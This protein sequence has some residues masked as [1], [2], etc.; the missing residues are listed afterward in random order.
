MTT[1][2]IEVIRNTI[3]I[4]DSIAYKRYSEDKA[5]DY[6]E[7]TSGKW[8]DEQKLIAPIIFPKF[9]EQILGFKLGETIGTEEPTLESRDTPDY[10][11]TDTRTHSFLFDCKGMDTF[12]LSKHYPQI[13]RY[14]E[15]QN[16]K[17]GVLVNM[18]DLTVYTN[19]SSEEVESFKFSFMELYKEFKSNFNTIL[20]N[21]NTK[22]F[23]RFVESFQYTPLTTEQKL[24][25]VIDAK[26]WVGTEILN[27]N[28]LTKR[29]HYIVE[30]IYED[31]ALKRYCQGD[32]VKL[33]SIKLRR[34]G[35][36]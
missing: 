35:R 6:L 15:S 23:L 21:E 24:K 12:E 2:D 33:L 34:D 8:V 7:Y 5:S 16:V 22:R 28:L 36:L 19:E 11:P 32:C 18:R 27:I 26:Q 17:Y 30:R 3:T 31:V 13:K 14:I 29:L 10:I 25:R 9:L 4:L 1:K 20:E